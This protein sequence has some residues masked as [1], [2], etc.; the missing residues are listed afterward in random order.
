MSITGGCDLLRDGQWAF[1]GKQH[2]SW[3]LIKGKKGSISKRR[4]D[5]HSRETGRSTEAAWVGGRKP[6][7][8]EH[9]DQSEEW[10]H[11]LICILTAVGRLAHS[12]S[13]WKEMNQLSVCCTDLDKRP[14]QLGPDQ[15]WRKQIFRRHKESGPSVRTVLWAVHVLLEFSQPTYGTHILSCIS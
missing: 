5:K 1:P 10:W 4:Q 13:W 6:V 8:L 14:R 9:K 2:L 11:C 3:G 12:N 15:W 7:W